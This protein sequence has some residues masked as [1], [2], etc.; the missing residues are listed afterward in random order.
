M[1]AEQLR[2]M[3]E[4]SNHAVDETG[5]LQWVHTYVTDDRL[6]CVY[7]AVD[8]SRIREHAQRGG[9]PCDEITRIHTIIDPVTGEG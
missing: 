5:G 1:T 7:I 9:F 6:F 4:R 8:E 2:G 3:S